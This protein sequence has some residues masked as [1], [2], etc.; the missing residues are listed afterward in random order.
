M[1]ITSSIETSCV[2]L[3]QYG[4]VQWPLWEKK[5]ERE[6]GCKL[7]IRCIQY[8][9]CWSNERGPTHQKS[10]TKPR[11]FAHQWTI[12]KQRST[13]CC[14]IGYIN[15]NSFWLLQDKFNIFH[16][17]C[18]FMHKSI[19][20]FDDFGQQDNGNNRGRSSFCDSSS[21][22]RGHKFSWAEI[23]GWNDTNSV[24]VFSLVFY[25]L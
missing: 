3:N 25:G 17:Q 18:C 5:R 13:F 23:G 19:F 10:L 8:S 20:Q 4:N 11:G 15:P 16:Y 1:S 24:F 12:F 14:Q 9:S 7:I 21:S 2:F 6:E 22:G